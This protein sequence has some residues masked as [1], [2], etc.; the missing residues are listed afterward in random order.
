MYLSTGPHCHPCVLS[1]PPPKQPGF[2]RSLRLFPPLPRRWLPVLWVSDL[3]R[4]FCLTLHFILPGAK[5]K[6]TQDFPETLRVPLGPNFPLLILVCLSQASPGASACGA[7]SAAA[8]LLSASMA[9][10]AL[11]LTARPVTE[12]VKI[13]QGNCLRTV[14]DPEEFQQKLHTLQPLGTV[15]CHVGLQRMLVWVPSFPRLCDFLHLSYLVLTS[16]P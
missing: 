14:D 3:I 15:V 2:S 7:Y 4:S 6:E 12:T 1:P 11:G 5:P 9:W 10:A 13:K 8:C 16:F